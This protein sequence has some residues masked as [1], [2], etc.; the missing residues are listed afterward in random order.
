MSFDG[1]LNCVQNELLNI[2]D[3]KFNLH[4]KSTDDHSL[5]VCLSFSDKK[6]ISISLRS[7]EID[8]KIHYPN[9]VC[10]SLFATFCSDFHRLWNSVKRQEFN[11]GSSGWKTREEPKKFAHTIWTLNFG[12][13]IVVQSVWNGKC[14]STTIVMDGFFSSSRLRKFAGE[15]DAFD[16]MECNGRKRRHTMSSSLSSLVWL[17]RCFKSN[18]K[19]DQSKQNLDE[20]KTMKIN[21]RTK[22]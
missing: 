18:S 13:A 7:D 22:K 15:H 5:P 12:V 10:R 2:F 11:S 3:T 8:G 9:S 16:C 4:I 1:R 14:F 6:L 20:A 17:C 19:W 21:C